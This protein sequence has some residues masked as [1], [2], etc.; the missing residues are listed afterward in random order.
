MHK[1]KYIHAIYNTI[2]RVLKFLL[3]HL[4]TI[5]RKVATLPRGATAL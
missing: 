4:A 2:W 3:I 5:V 1:N